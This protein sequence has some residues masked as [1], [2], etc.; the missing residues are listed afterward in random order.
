MTWN[1]TDYSRFQES[2][3]RG[4]ENECPVDLLRDPS[5]EPEK[6]ENTR[7]ELLVV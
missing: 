2:W 4:E 3:K 7:G 1:Y 6:A 5:Y